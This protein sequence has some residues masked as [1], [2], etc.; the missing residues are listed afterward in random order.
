MVLWMS[1]S[2]SKPNRTEHATSNRNTHRKLLTEL[3]QLI[4]DHVDDYEGSRSTDAGRTVHQ[5][6]SRRLTRWQL[7]LQRLLT[8]VHLVEEVEDAAGVRGHAVIRPS[9]HGYRVKKNKIL[10]KKLIR[11]YLEVVMVD[12]PFA[13]GAFHGYQEFSEGVV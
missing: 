9:L 2:Q 8:F 1:I 5:D 7:L 6:G 4:E 10:N 13:V 3:L 11:C 12:F